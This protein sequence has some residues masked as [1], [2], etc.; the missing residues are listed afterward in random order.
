M[1][2]ACTRN[3][4]KSR[5]SRRIH[6]MSREEEGKHVERVK[7]LSYYNINAKATRASTREYVLR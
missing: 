4:S 6:K 1:A 7:T 3:K 5:L 2:S